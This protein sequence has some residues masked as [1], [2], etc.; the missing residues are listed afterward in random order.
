MDFFMGVLFF[1][2][3]F[4]DLCEKYSHSCNDHKEY[5]L[6]NSGQKYR[7][8]TKHTREEIY[9]KTNLRLCESELHETI[10]E[11]MCLIS[12]H[13]ILSL[14]DASSDNIDKVY[15]IESKN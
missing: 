11:V 15:E 5:D 6:A 3:R 9:N 2:H 13:R 12:F 10:V 4:E 1:L 8:N 7:C 14:E